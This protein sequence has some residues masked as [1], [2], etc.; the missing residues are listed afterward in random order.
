MIHK[1]DGM[2]YRLSGPNPLMEGQEIWKKE[3]YVLHNFK[4]PTELPSQIEI[5]E[6]EKPAIEHTV[7][8]LS[9]PFV[10]REEIKT[11]IKNL[12]EFYCLPAKIQKIKDPLYEEYVSRITYGTPHKFSCE[13]LKQADI[14]ILIKT[15]EV[16]L[17]SILF[18]KSMRRWW[19][20]SQVYKDFSE[21]IISELKP[22]F[23]SIG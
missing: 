13:L 5:V 6:K 20:V 23:T 18:Q 11:N 22:D 10:A 1:K 2:P 15:T 4:L 16:P 3:E 17:N 19:K 8:E 14:G 9:E 7:V 12:E 21:C